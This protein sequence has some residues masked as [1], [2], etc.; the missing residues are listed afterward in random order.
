MY[1]TCEADKRRS[2]NH[3]RACVLLPRRAGPGRAEAVGVGVGVGE[4][5][6]G[7]A[8]PDGQCGAVRVSVH[9]RT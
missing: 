4:A 1:T 6:H 3:T 7:A 8:R 9:G 5:R 2:V